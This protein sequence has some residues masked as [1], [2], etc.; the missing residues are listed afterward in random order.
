MIETKPKRIEVGP[1]MEKAFKAGVENY[2]PTAGGHDLQE[3]G[4]VTQVSLENLRELVELCGPV[5][6]IEIG[7]NQGMLVRFPGFETYL[8]TGFSI[9]Y[10]GEGQAGLAMFA[11]ECGF[12][13]GS[14]LP[15]I[16]AALHADFRGALFMRKKD[17]ASVTKRGPLDMQVCVPASWPDEQV[18]AFA[19][20]ENPCG[21]SH[22]W[23]IRREDDR[24]LAG[25]PERTPCK[26][27]DGFVHIMLD[28]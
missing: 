13:K 4:G 25:D 15:H 3:E 10:R 1:E 23:R 9:G 17:G 22:G 26:S 2:V 28:A 19:D 5:Q 11:E 24:A 18:K 20:A 8:A 12:G 14:E 7:K 27:R 21:T 6:S 16:V